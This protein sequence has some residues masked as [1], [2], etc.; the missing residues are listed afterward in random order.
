MTFIVLGNATVDEFMAAPT[1]PSPGQTVV[2]GAPARDLGGK[3]ANQAM[4]LKRAGA[5]V[6]LVA[7]IGQ[8]HLADWIV[9]QIEAEGFLSDD[10][11]RLPLPSDRS[12]IFVGTDGEN[13]IASIVDCSAAVTPAQAERALAD[14]AV[15]DILVLQ[16]NLTVEATRAACV[17]ARARGV[18]TLFNPSPMRVGFADLLPLVELLVVNESEAIQ[19]SGKQALEECLTG[20]HAAGALEVVMTLGGR[21]S[22]A[23]GRDGTT[24]VA[25]SPVAVVDTTGAGDT[26]MGVLAAALFDRTMPMSEA[27][28]IASM[29][30]G[31]TVTRPGTRSAFPSVAELEALFKTP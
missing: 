1:W 18:R 26:Y 5:A 15:G 8:D 14:A 16:G 31:V 10:L 2:V 21:G 17:V 7:G 3:G 29:A 13:A 28:R 11:L 20:L 25:A 4:V 9:E 30:A 27:M 23:H 24:F 22:M 12:L 19:L 6:R